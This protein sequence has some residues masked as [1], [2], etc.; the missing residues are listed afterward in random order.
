MNSGRA[1]SGRIPAAENVSA[2]VDDPGSPT[3]RRK[4]IRCQHNAGFGIVKYFIIQSGAPTNGR[5]VAA[6]MARS[7]SRVVDTERPGSGGAGAERFPGARLSGWRDDRQ[8]AGRNRREPRQGQ[9]SIRINDRYRICFRWTE[10]GA[11]DV[12]IVDYH[13]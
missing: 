12:E 1:A 9:H 10:S 7:T 3:P 6:H 13:S 11:Q 5:R 8:R 2:A 4:S